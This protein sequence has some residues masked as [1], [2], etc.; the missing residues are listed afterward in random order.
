VQRL[1]RRDGTEIAALIV[2]P[3]CGNMGVIFR[4]VPR[5]LRKITEVMGVDFDG[6]YRISS[7]AGGAWGFT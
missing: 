4:P 6:D 3:I 7:R 5:A 2:E 1:F